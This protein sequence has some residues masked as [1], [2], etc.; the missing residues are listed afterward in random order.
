[1]RPQTKNE[2]LLLALLAAIVVLGGS[3][4]GYRWI[5]AKQASLQMTYAGL[6]ADQREAQVDLQQSDLWTQRKTWI[7]D[8]E[9]TLG[10]E[11]ETKAQVLAFVLKGARAHKLEIVEQNLS[12][13]Q[14]GPGG[15]RVNVSVTV[16]GAMESLTEWLTELQKPDQFYAVSLFSLKADQDQKS[17]VCR[18]QLARYFKGGS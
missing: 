1:M 3:F 10:D 11:G 9:P 14:Q 17:M 4:F 13:V 6:L 5:A 12:D 16:K 18:L 2:K 15:T 7:H 8:H